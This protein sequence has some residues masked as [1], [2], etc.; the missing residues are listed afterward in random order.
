MK[1]E[2]VTNN[3]AAIVREVSI[4]RQKFIIRR[5][6]VPISE[7]NVKT[8]QFLELLK[9]LDSYLDDNNDEVRGIIRNYCMA[10]SITRESI[11][12][13]IRSY[14][15]STIRNYYEMRLYDILT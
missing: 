3:T 15:D 14:P 12:K 10:N 1:K 8:L 9:I 2:I 4:G 11:D 13:H 7:K 6:N 5:T